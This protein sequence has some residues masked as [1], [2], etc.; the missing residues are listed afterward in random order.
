MRSNRQQVCSGCAT[1]FA[2]PTLL[3]LLSL[4]SSRQTMIP[5]IATMIHSLRLQIGPTGD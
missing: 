4:L 2:T 3:Q 1:L 5:V